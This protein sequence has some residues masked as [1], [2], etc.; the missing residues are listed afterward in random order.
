MKLI[1]FLFY[2]PPLGAQETDSFGVIA[3]IIFPLTKLINEPAVSILSATY[4]HHHS[5]QLD[6][7]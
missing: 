4:H 7:H 3:L 6:N 1:Y 2:L 5:P